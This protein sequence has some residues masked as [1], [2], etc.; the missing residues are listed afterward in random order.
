L[1]Y[2]F[3]PFTAEFTTAYH[4]FKSTHHGEEL[5]P[6]FEKWTKLATVDEWDHH[7]AN[8]CAVTIC[9]TISEMWYL[10]DK[11]TDKVDKEI[12]T[13]YAGQQLSLDFEERFQAKCGFLRVVNENSP[14]VHDDYERN[15]YYPHNWPFSIS[16]YG[17]ASEN[18]VA[19]SY[20]NND[21]TFLNRDKEYLGRF[22]EWGDQR[23]AIY[24]GKDT[25]RGYV[26][27]D[28]TVFS[29][30]RQRGK[31]EK[32]GSIVDKNGFLIAKVDPSYDFKYVAVEF[33]Y[34]GDHLNH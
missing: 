16:E 3:G 32:D 29:D 2:V 30:Y 31:I 20:Y 9:R 18:G 21:L 26:K 11:I 17:V 33:F 27:F 13:K 10:I 25:V 7:S 34:R 14:S 1:D 24:I 19:V 15:E 8:N 4:Y 6:M 28:G 5:K 23:Y 22:K 12:G